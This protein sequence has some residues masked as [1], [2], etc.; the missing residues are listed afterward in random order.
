MRRPG[1]FF[2]HRALG[3]MRPFSYRFDQDDILRV[4]AFIDTLGDAE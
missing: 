2:P 4:M 3:A 1:L